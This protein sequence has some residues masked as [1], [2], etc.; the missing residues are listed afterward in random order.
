MRARGSSGRGE[1]RDERFDDALELEDG[2]VGCGIEAALG[3]RGRGDA[4]GELRG[5]VDLGDVGGVG[6]GGAGE[7]LSLLEEANLADVAVEVVREHGEH[8]GHE[9][10]AEEGGLFGEGVLHGN[11]SILCG[12]CGSDS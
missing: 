11:G 4:E 2:S 9:R 7:D 6:C 8:A 3:G 10:G 12:P 5:L 1:A